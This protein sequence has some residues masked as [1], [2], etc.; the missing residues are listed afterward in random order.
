MHVQVK[1]LHIFSYLHFSTFFLNM[2][3][4]ASAALLVFLVASC[5]GHKGVKKDGLLKTRLNVPANSEWC[6]KEFSVHTDSVRRRLK[7]PVMPNDAVL[8]TILLDGCFWYCRSG[9]GRE[10]W[11]STFFDDFNRMFRY[12]LGTIRL[13]SFRTVRYHFGSPA[14]AD[15]LMFGQLKQYDYRLYFGASLKTDSCINC[16]GMVEVTDERGNKAITAGGSAQKETSLTREQLD[17]IF[18]KDFSEMG[19]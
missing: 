2:K 12:E 16:D 3:F 15:S 11:L 6:I 1:A 19:R 14:R 17:S 13:D 4:S 9:N 18:K 8:Q 7:M 10:F 5:N